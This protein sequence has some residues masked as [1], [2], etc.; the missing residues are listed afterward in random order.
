MTQTSASNN[1]SASVSISEDG[2][3]EIVA[4][5]LEAQSGGD[6]ASPRELPRDLDLVS[7]GMIDSF[8]FLELVADVEDALGV[9]I[10]FEDL[11]ADELTVV[12]PFCR[13]VAATV[14]SRLRG[15]L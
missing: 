3:A 5:A 10:D 2:V 15:A 7:S 13:H 14:Q 9:E 1:G 12:G 11:D 4:E 6:P 8:G